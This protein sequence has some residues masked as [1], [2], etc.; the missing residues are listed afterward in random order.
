[1]QKPAIRLLATDLDG[2]VMGHRDDRALYPEFKAVLDELRR[3]EGM[4]WVICTGRHYGSYRAFARSMEKAGVAP[5]FV[6]THRLRVFERTQKGYRIKPLYTAAVLINNVRSHR[7]A[8]RLLK[9]MHYHLCNRGGGVRR[10]LQLPHHFTLRFESEESATKSMTWVRSQVKAMP[11]LK[12]CRSD[13]EID[14]EQIACRKGLSVRTLAGYLAIARDEILTIGDGA[15]DLCMLDRRVACHTGCPI[16]ADEETQLGV[17]T[18]G[19]HISPKL[20]L[21]GVIDIIRATCEGRVSSEIPEEKPEMPRRRRSNGR[22]SQSHSREKKHLT[23]S[24]ILGA[25]VVY[26]TVVVF[27]SFGA[28]PFSGLIMK[29]FHAVFDLIEKLF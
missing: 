21:A 12:V 6:V 9:R 11:S 10:V 16:N 3:S 2:T 13:R 7:R 5:D 28:I 14:V 15:S 4:Q 17:Q 25:A 29:P 8:R 23:R 19:G 26:I 27:A 24:Y 18:M 1:M 20:T 22:H